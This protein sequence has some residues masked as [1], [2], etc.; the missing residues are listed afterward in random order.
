MAPKKGSGVAGP[1]TTKL[2][3]LDFY[4][5]GEQDAIVAKPVFV[6]DEKGEHLFIRAG[7]STRL[8]SSKESIDNCNIRWR[9]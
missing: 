4:A 3:S 9:S 1:G 5:K 8:L 2:S 7:N 6:T